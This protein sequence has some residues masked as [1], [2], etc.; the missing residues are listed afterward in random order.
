MSSS[1]FDL[2]GDAFTKLD[3]LMQAMGDT[4]PV[5]QA[6]GRIFVT[7]IQL[8]FKE[9]RNPWGV[10]WAPLKVRSGKPLIDTRRLLS[11]I[12]YAATSDSVEVGTNVSYAPYHHFGFTVH[13]KES[14]KDLYFHQDRSG[15][16]GNRFVKKG[17][18]NFVQQAII[19]AHD[20]TVPARPFLPLTASNIVELPDSWTNDAMRAF[21][22]FI[23]GKL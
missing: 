4:T 3:H 2:T 9:S 15:N 21:A 20:V 11:S 23:E 14:T 1:N 12:V 16:V 19:K 10:P 8:G 13:K 17:K 18:S 5:M 7:K 6:I 22:R